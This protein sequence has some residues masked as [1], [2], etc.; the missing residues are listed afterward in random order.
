M[1]RLYRPTTRPARRGSTRGSART[2]SVPPIDVHQ[3]LWP[4]PFLAALRARRTPPRL[5]GWT[6]ELP[7]DAPFAVDPAAHDPAT[8]AARADGAICVAPSAALGLDRLAPQETARLA[9]AWLEGALALPHRFRAWAMDREPA[10]LRDAVDDGAI[11]LEL[12]ADALASPDGLD[13]LAP[14]L[15]VLQERD[16]AL[17]VH[18][19][20]AVA[21]GRPA[22]WVPVVPY[23]AGLHAAWWA[24]QDGGRARFPGLRVCFAALAGL[25][26]LHEERRLARGGSPVPAGPLT[27]VETS[28]YGTQAVSATIRALGLDAIC[29]GSDAPYAQ[30]SELDLDANALDAIHHANPVRLVS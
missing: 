8:R 21:P 15:G 9:A 16:R 1:A 22:W 6:L 13:R 29:H 12:A 14:L 4:E 27:F 10:A 20:P 28:S 5:D 24:W 26:P 11:G 2:A 7:G 17:L 18:P 3:H 23:V 19:G 30:P 25:G